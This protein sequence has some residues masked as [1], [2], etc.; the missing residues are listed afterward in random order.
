MKKGK[1]LP[2]FKNEEEE[3]EFWATHNLTDY[4]DNFKE[5]KL[6]FSELR[7]ST[8][9]ITIR[10]PESLLSALK[11]L[12]HQKDVPYQSLMKILLAEKIKEEYSS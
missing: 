6:D 9:S 1:T 3:R 5:V 8:K 2:K 4:L 12:A 7:P 10:L 11:N